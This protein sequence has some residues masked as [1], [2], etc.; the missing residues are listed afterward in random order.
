MFKELC[1]GGRIALHL[2]CSLGLATL[3]LRVRLV[4]Q[5]TNPKLQNKCNLHIGPAIILGGQGGGKEGKYSFTLFS[6]RQRK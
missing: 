6:W 3:A 2:F 4:L 5:S 1:S